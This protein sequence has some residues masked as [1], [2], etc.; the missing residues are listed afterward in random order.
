MGGMLRAGPFKGT[1]SNPLTWP[2]FKEAKLTGHNVDCA[3]SMGP[4]ACSGHS[5]GT[6]LCDSKWVTRG[7]SSMGFNSMS[8]FWRPKLDGSNFNWKD[9]PRHPNILNLASAEY[10]DVALHG[11]AGRRR[12]QLRI[13]RTKRRRS[14]KRFSLCQSSSRC[15]GTLC[16]DP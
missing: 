1:R 16:F 11:K 15:D 10:G 2:L 4:T 13:S 12:D 6:A 8:E 3:S 5:T 7:V 14:E 9:T